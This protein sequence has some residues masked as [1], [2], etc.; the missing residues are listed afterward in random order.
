M[1]KLQEDADGTT[2]SASV[3]RMLD[4]LESMG[5]FKQRAVEGCWRLKV[6]CWVD[7][8]DMIDGGGPAGV[9]GAPRC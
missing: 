6:S 5:Y 1:V 8:R 9:P 7:S 2:M 4:A 3:H